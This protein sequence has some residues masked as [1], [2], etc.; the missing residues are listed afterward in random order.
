[1]KTARFLAASGLALSLPLGACAPAVQ[2]EVASAP[3]STP[4]T[5][6]ETQGIGQLF[7]R[8]D[9]AQLAMSPEGKAYRGIRDA[10]YGKWGDASD[11]AEERDIALLRTTLAQMRANYDPATLDDQLR[12]RAV[13][14]DNRSTDHFL[15]PELPTGHLTVR[16]VAPQ[17]QFGLRWIA[18][19][20]ASAQFQRVELRA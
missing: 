16:E 6:P 17:A 8:Y 2:G 5:T 15:P 10:D 3:A 14:I 12:G 11:A 19:H 18:T 4:A 13:E 7:E 9:A 20:L 1:M